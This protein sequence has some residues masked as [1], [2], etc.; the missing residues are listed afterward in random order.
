MTAP[1]IQDI[2]RNTLT[3]EQKYALNILENLD[4]QQ[5]NKLKNLMNLSH[6]NIVGPT[7]L[8]KFLNLCQAHGFDLSENGVHQFKQARE[9]DDQGANS[10]KIGATTALIYYK[11]IF[12]QPLWME[13][14]KDEIGVKEIPGEANNKR[15]VEYHRTTIGR[16][17]DKTPWCSSFACWCMQQ[18]DLPHPHS[19]WA[20]HWR[21]WSG[22]RKLDRPQY[23][24]IVV[25][26]KSAGGNDGHVGFFVEQ[27]DSNHIKVLG[28]NQGDEVNISTFSLNHRGLQG[29]YWPK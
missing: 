1:T 9:L 25:L 6:P 8:E 13:I 28:G 18:A 26:G 16:Y 4:V 24:C 19:A 12:K 3:I 17:P 11:E 15:I 20:Y 14:A 27:V 22:G 10:G 23:G 2:D 7:T 5:V 21:T 29:Y